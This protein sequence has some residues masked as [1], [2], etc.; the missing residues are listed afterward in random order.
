[1]L[2]YYGDI[3]EVHEALNGRQKKIERAY[4]E[5]LGDQWFKRFKNGIQ[6]LITPKSFLDLET[7]KKTMDIEISPAN[8]FCTLIARDSMPSFSVNGS[9]KAAKAI[10]TYPGFVF[11]RQGFENSKEKYEAWG[12]DPYLGP[13]IHEYDHFLI[14]LLQPKPFFIFILLNIDFLG[15]PAWPLPVDIIM[16]YIHRKYQ[17]RPCEELQHLI[18][19]G[20]NLGMLD[21]AHEICTRALDDAVLR[22]L[23]FKTEGFFISEPKSLAIAIS[24][25]IRTKFFINKGD[26]L[27]GFPIGERLKRI[28]EWQEFFTPSNPVQANFSAS[29]QKARFTKEPLNEDIEDV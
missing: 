17:D 9:F 8:K 2:K 7:L 22:L 4:R 5:I 23:G 26:P 24:K 27:Y 25:S 15:L 29:V 13:I 28:I 21:E 16:E 11:H 12:I 3:Q 10:K 6:N 1:M 18:L 20:I 14:Y 19:T